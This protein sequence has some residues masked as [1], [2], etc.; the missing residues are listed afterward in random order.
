MLLRENT[1][2]DYLRP[3]SLLEKLACE[4]SFPT[5]Q[6]KKFPQDGEYMEEKDLRSQK[7]PQAGL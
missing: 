6:G 2:E 4:R 5:T 7:K 1:G 3:Q